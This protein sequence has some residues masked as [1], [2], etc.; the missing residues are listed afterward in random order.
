[1][2][3]CGINERKDNDENAYISGKDFYLTDA[4]NDKKTFE[5]EYVTC[6]KDI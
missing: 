1:M 4:D 2:R 3:N 6:I 5:K